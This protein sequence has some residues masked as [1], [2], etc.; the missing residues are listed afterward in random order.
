MTE[1]ILKIDKVEKHY[2]LPRRR[3]LERRRS[4]KAVD[5]VSLAVAPGEVLGIVGESGSGKSTLAR[6]AMAFETPDA[7]AVTFMGEDMTRISPDQNALLR[8]KLQVVF[9]DPF[10]SL[11]PRRTV[12]WSVSE[13]LLASSFGAAQRRER[14]IAAMERVGLSADLAERYPHQFGRPAPTHSHCARHHHR[15]GPDRRR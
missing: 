7:G 4:F 3:L 15:P 14:M 5:G 10:S 13:P 2:P 11:D 9:Q 8:R 1:P 6:L 12:G